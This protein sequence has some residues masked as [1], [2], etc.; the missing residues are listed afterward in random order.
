MEKFST[1]LILSFREEQDSQLAEQCRIKNKPPHAGIGA[2]QI[3]DIIYDEYNN[4]EQLARAV[5][6]SI[7]KHHSVETVSFANYEIMD[8]CISEMKR[9]LISE[10]GMDYGFSQSGKSEKLTDLI[11][12]IDKEWI[13]YLFIVRILRLCDQK[14]TENFEKYYQK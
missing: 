10:F 7:L 12:T 6:C 9:L 2:A 3:Y 11:P 8:K 1:I 4:D 14:S 13:L 5:S